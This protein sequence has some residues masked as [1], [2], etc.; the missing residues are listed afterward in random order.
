MTEAR[1][2]ARVAKLEELAS[3]VRIYFAAAVLFSGLI[4]AGI[5][6]WIHDVVA[7]SPMATE[8]AKVQAELNG[9][10]A[11]DS[12]RQSRLDQLQGQ[13]DGVT[14]VLTNEH[15]GRNTQP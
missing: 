10:K 7:S 1:T 15:F 4:T 12:E 6:V 9:L 5:T 2:D 14:L 3:R 8:L 11:N 13:W